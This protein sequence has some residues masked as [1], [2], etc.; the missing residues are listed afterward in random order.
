MQL[1][2]HHTPYLERYPALEAIEDPRLNEIAFPGPDGNTTLLLYR[3]IQYRVI[4]LNEDNY[5][6]IKKLLEIDSRLITSEQFHELLLRFNRLTIPRHSHYQNVVILGRLLSGA[7]G[8]DYFS[9]KLLNIIREKSLGRLNFRILL[10]VNEYEFLSHLKAIQTIH[11]TPSNFGGCES[12]VGSQAKLSTR[13]FATLLDRQLIQQDEFH[14]IVKNLIENYLHFAWSSFTEQ[15]RLNLY[16]PGFLSQ[17]KF[18]ALRQ[19]FPDLEISTSPT[20]EFK[21]T[22]H[23]LIESL[24]NRIKNPKALFELHHFFFSEYRI[25]R[26]SM[27]S[28][29]SISPSETYPLFYLASDRSASLNENRDPQITSVH[30]NVTHIGGFHQVSLSPSLQFTA[31]ITS[32]PQASYAASSGTTPTQSFANHPINFGRQ[33]ISLKPIK[34]PIQRPNFSR[35]HI[36]EGKLSALP[37]PLPIHAPNNTDYRICVFGDGHGNAIKL[38]QFLILHNIFECSE[39]IYR[40]IFNFYSRSQENVEPIHLIEIKT[41][42]DTLKVVPSDF[43]VKIIALGDLL[44]DRGLKDWLTLVLL[45]GLSKEKQLKLASPFRTMMLNFY[46]VIEKLK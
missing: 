24:N 31:Y 13:H 3:L 23:R 7:S 25:K 41:L 28:S 11:I 21:L 2:S 16:S 15:N 4:D 26:N 40:A 12:A 1:Y 20:S 37:K 42:I 30:A 14:Q 35:L 32:T 45:E 6:A 8:N 39:E 17:T 33:A 27:R 5:L 46:V 34:K 22:L 29:N 10:G 43:R 44:C 38:F 18:G 9:I 19:Y 36:L